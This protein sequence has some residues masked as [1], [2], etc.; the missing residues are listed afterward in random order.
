[1][2]ATATLIQIGIQKAGMPR[3]LP[4]DHLARILKQLLRVRN[5]RLPP[6]IRPSAAFCSSP[7]AD[8]HASV[9]FRIGLTLSALLA[10]VE[11]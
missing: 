5:V 3:T 11:Q 9:A 2:A 4:R 6:Q 1:M 7:K 10:M 8:V